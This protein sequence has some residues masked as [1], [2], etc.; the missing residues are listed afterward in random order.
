MTHPR[1]NLIGIGR[2]GTMR[3]AY[4]ESCIALRSG[5]VQ[6]TLLVFSLLL[7]IA[8]AMGIIRTQARQTDARFAEQENSLVKEI[9]AGVLTG[10][11]ETTDVKGANSDKR[12]RL[13][14]QLR[15]TAKSPYL[16]S[17]A[18]N[19]WNISLH[20]SPLSALSVGASN[21][22]PDLY[23]VQGVSLSETVQRNDDIRPVATV[24]GPFDTTFMVMVIA[25]LVIIG[26]TFNA[27]SRDRETTLQNLIV[28]QTSSLGKLIALRCLVRTSWVIVLVTCIVN[29]MLLFAFANQFDGKLVVNLAIW[30]VGAA[31]Y[32]LVWAALSLFVN[33]FA[34]SSSANSAALLLLWLLIVLIIPRWVA[35]AVEETVSTFPE[36]ALAKR[37]KIVFDQASKQVD[38]LSQRFQLDH[39]EVELELEDEQ[40]RTLI[41][42]LLAHS[43][44]GRQAP[45][46]VSS[47]YSGQSLR[48]RYVN[49]G[50]WISPAISFRNQSDLCSGNSECDFI[51]FSVKAAALHAQLKEVFLKPSVTNEECTVEII[52]ALPDFH[53]SEIPLGSVFRESIAS[54]GSL[55]IWLI[56]ITSLGVRRF[57]VKYVREENAPTPQQKGNPRA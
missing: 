24:Y 56:I 5:G 45:E 49:Y 25:P 46:N 6:I 23:R 52:A 48:T 29:G 36:Q 21:T 18:V 34:K 38:E 4:W 15:M 17:H 26:L 16:M 50:N 31:A 12:S 9:F 42:Y 47:H 7:C 37:E 30:N 3:L 43:E 10:T 8:T 39:P 35:N 13:T 2:P 28:A 41:G 22:W 44:A 32:L 53:E 51:A 55:F 54:V 1:D 27:S 11:L 20:P 40:Q 19:L 14:K 57:R 33:A